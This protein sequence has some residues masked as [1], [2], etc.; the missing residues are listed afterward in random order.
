VRPARG[1]ERDHV[2]SHESDHRLCYPF[3]RA[4]QRQSYLEIGVRENFGA[5]RFSTFSTV[6]VLSGRAACRAVRP[7]ALDSFLCFKLTADQR[8]TLFVNP[9]AR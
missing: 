3:Y 6:S 8:R 2:D 7:A 1:D 5:A 9:S 4:V